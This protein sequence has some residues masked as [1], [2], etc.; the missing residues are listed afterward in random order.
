MELP[1]LIGGAT[2]SRQHTAVKIAPAYAQ[3]VVHVVDASRVVGV[4]SELLDPERKPTLDAEN[5]IELQDRLRAQHAER[6]KTPLL[7]YRKALANRTP[8]EWRTDDVTPPPFTGARVVEP[9]LADLRAFIDWT[10]FFTAW[11]LKGRYPQILEH[12]GHGEAAREL[13]EHANELLDEIVAD[14]SMPGAR[15]VRILARR[16]RGRRHR[17]RRRRRCSRCSASRSTTARSTI[18]RTDRWPTSSR[19]ADLGIADHV[20]GFAVTAGLGADE[21]AK[22]FEADHDDYRAIMVKALA[23]RLAEAFAE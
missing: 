19:R 8:I 5:R 23:D 22:R 4:V 12:P 17:P 18:A 10:F 11:E 9:E 21:L 6:E 1:L 13:F 14:G 7:P 2:T 15:R 3:P 20:G 16:S